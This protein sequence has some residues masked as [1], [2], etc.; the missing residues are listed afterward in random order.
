M[1]RIRH[2]AIC[3]PRWDTG[4]VDGVDTTREDYLAYL[5]GTVIERE[6]LDDVPAHD[7]GRREGWAVRRRG[8][9]A[10]SADVVRLAAPFSD[11]DAITGTS[12]TGT[13]RAIALASG[14][15]PGHA[16]GAGA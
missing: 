2:V 4:R 8:D 14:G 13:A 7:D 6:E 15:E 16:A 3:W 5:A 10:V 12:P 11:D 9:R 1:R